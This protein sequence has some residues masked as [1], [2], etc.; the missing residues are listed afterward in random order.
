MTHQTNEINIPVIALTITIFVYCNTFQEKRPISCNKTKFDCYFMVSAW[1]WY[2]LKS[3]WQLCFSLHWKHPCFTVMQDTIFSQSILIPYHSLIWYSQLKL[4]Q[5]KSRIRIFPVNLE[6]S[7]QV[8]RIQNNLHAATDT[9]P[10]N[11]MYLLQ[12]FNFEHY[13]IIVN[14]FNKHIKQNHWFSIIQTVLGCFLS[15][16]TA[17]HIFMSTV[18]WVTLDLCPC[19]FN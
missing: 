5:K 7:S 10:K 19:L 2:L 18:M 17:S 15:L 13:Q 9:K 3:A 1:N 14:D 11:C 6:K 8:L 12:L 16:V 4:C